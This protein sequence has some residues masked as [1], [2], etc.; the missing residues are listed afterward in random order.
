MKALVL[1]LD[2]F[3]E[4]LPLEHRG[5]VAS[6]NDVEVLLLDLSIAIHVDLLDLHRR[7]E[8]LD[9]LLLVLGDVLELLDRPIL[10]SHLIGSAVRWLDLGK[11]GI[12]DVL[13]P[14]IQLLRHEAPLLRLDFLHLRY[15]AFGLE[16][17]NLGLRKASG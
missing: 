5:P 12:L 15:L 9:Q 13:E 11:V 17:L 10:Q 7:S 1:L 4:R 2:D 14:P 8:Q 3:L 6:E 16:V